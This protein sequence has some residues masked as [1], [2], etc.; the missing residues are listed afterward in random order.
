MYSFVCINCILLC[1]FSVLG[2]G[3]I[4]K[5]LVVGHMMFS[6]QLLIFCRKYNL[7]ST[8][9]MKTY[10]MGQVRKRVAIS[11]LAPV[12]ALTWL[13]VSR[14]SWLWMLQ[15][16][17]FLLGKLYD[18]DQLELSFTFSSSRWDTPDCLLQRRHDVEVLL[19]FVL[20]LSPFLSPLIFQC[21]RE[22][23]GTPCPVSSTYLPE[24]TSVYVPGF[25]FVLSTRTNLLHKELCLFYSLLN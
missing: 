17:V 23:V 22:L 11:L 25:F 3:E 18:N 1:Y 20:L 14:K 13:G 12:I 21:L 24:T 19:L 16:S 2:R 4:Q 9:L 7:Q 6:L 5:Y 15:Y 10:W 8:Y